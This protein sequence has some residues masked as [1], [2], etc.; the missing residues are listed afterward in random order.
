VSDTL[1]L[2]RLK[3][4]LERFVDERTEMLAELKALKLPKLSHIDPERRR[5][6]VL[7]DER[8]AK[9]NALISRVEGGSVG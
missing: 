7:T 9:I 5:S 8:I 2:S 1:D 6:I 3:A 4:N